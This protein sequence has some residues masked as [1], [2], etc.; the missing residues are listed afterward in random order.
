MAMTPFY[1]V[2]FYD[3]PRTIVLQLKGKW[4][5]LQSLFD[6]ESDD[7]ETEYSVY[8]L[9][10]FFQLPSSGSPWKFLEELPSEC[11][12]KVPVEAVQFDASKRKALNASILEKIRSRN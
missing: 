1:Y 9:P 5:L 11:I 7:Y 4:V 3:F 2:D 12:G 8:Q 6:E 10:D